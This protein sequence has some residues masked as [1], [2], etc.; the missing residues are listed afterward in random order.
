LT[1]EQEAKCHGI[2]HGASLLAAA[3][4]SGLA[5]LPG[6]DNAVIVPIQVTMTVALGQ[7]FGVSLA[8]SAARVVMTETRPQLDTKTGRVLSPKEIDKRLDK[9]LPKPRRIPGK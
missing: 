2:I 6:S 9:Y 4:G 7:I 1:N 8:E 3:A 5:Q